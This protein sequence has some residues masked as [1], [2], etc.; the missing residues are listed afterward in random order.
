[1]AGTWQGGCEAALA[2][3]LM[4]AETR[5]TSPM[6]MAKA[7]NDAFR[8]GREQWPLDLADAASP[9]LKPLWGHGAARDFSPHR[10]MCVA[11]QYHLHHHWPRG[12]P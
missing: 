6:V 4:L 5:A 12:C 8:Y 2:L 11:A 1:M 9:S 3:P 10:V 7:T